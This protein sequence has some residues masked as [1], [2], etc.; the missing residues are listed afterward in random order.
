VLNACFK[1]FDQLAH[2]KLSVVYGKFF[3]HRIM[4]KQSYAT[5]LLMSFDLS[6]KQEAGRAARSQK[7]GWFPPFRYFYF[8]ETHHALYIPLLHFPLL[9]FLFGLQ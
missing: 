8:K 4:R 9:L 1:L 2:G 7:F 3:R 5:N 6:G